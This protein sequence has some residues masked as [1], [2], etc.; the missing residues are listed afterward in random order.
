MCGYRI[1][2]VSCTVLLQTLHSLS[3]FPS[4]RPWNRL[5]SFSPTVPVARSSRSG[6]TEVFSYKTRV[7]VFATAVL[8]Q[9]VCL[10]YNETSFLY[11]FLSLTLSLD[12]FQ[13]AP[14]PVSLPERRII[15]SP[16]LYNLT[17]NAV[18]TRS[19]FFHEMNTGIKKKTKISPRE[20]RPAPQNTGSHFNYKIFPDNLL[21]NERLIVIAVPGEVNEH[22]PVSKHRIETLS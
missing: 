6:T 2:C 22:D 18:S 3:F 10:D 7:D 12:L 8:S 16:R 19:I 9:C 13:A 15:S 11:S 5:L 20:F 21:I 1:R 4:C 17:L 14:P